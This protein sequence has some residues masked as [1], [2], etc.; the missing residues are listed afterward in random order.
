MATDGVPR[1]TLYGRNGC[2]LCEDMAAALRG[3]QAAHRFAFERVDVD[4]DADLVRRYG[5]RVP[6]LACGAHE[7]CHARLDAPAVTAF[8]SGF[9]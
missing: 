1:L 6:V 3:L 4:R 8:L 9:R 7:L 5:D 2:H